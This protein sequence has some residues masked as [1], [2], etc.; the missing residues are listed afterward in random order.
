MCRPVSSVALGSP[1]V[2][3]YRAPGLLRTLDLTRGGNSNVLARG[4]ITV[5]SHAQSAP[6]ICLNWTTRSSSCLPVGS[7]TLVRSPLVRSSAIPTFVRIYGIR[8][9]AA[10]I[11]T[12]PATRPNWGRGA[13]GGWVRNRLY[14]V[15]KKGIVGVRIIKD[16]RVLMS[17]SSWVRWRLCLKNASVWTQWVVSFV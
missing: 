12:I 7:A 2:G 10:T 11:S 6:S 16:Y 3:P 4:S 17:V 1:P 5:K 13:W 14:L 9:P 15:G 8:V